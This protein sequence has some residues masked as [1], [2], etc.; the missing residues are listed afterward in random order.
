MMGDPDSRGAATRGHEY[1]E[2]LLRLQT[3]RW[4]QW[5]DVQAPFRWNLRRLHPGFM[6]DIGCGIGRNLVHF[7]RQAVGVD[8]NEHCVAAATARGLTAFTPAALRASPEYCRPSRFDSLLLAHVAEHMKEDEV[9]GLVAEYEALLRPG[10][11]LIVLTPQEA[12]FRSDTTHVEF[13]DFERLRRI[14]ER[15]G[16]VVERTFSFP[17]PRWA[18]RLFTYNEFVVVGRKP[19]APSVSVPA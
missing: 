18:G 15:L 11:R 14:C 7:P 12:G 5:L 10:G 4:K 17:F 9:V 16:F 2:R 13:M 3:P 6:L 1:A 8:A 19:L